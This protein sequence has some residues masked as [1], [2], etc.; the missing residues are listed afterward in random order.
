MQNILGNYLS[1]NE[2]IIDIEF[3]M[4]DQLNIELY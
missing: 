1:F 2:K 4:V 3:G